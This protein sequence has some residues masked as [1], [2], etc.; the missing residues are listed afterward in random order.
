[1]YKEWKNFTETKR[2]EMELI[3]SEETPWQWIVRKVTGD[4]PL[5]SKLFK[6]NNLPTA[7]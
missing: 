4:S 5:R 1:M 3:M 6:T 2:R 7:Y